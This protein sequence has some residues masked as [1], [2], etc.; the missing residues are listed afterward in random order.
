ML[1]WIAIVGW[2]G[3]GAAHAQEGAPASDAPSPSADDA[4]LPPSYAEGWWW[5]RVRGPS[6]ALTSLATAPGRPGWWAAVN[7]SGEV[8]VRP[9]EGEEAVGVL[10]GTG[11]NLQDTDPRR[12]I[13]NR[14]REL[15]DRLQDASQDAGYA[16]DLTDSSALDAIQRELQN[17]DDQLNELG[18][19]D[20]AVPPAVIGDL[21]ALPRVWF[22]ASA[23][24][25]GRGDGLW[26]SDDFGTS[27]RQV[28]DV[29]THAFAARSDG[30]WWVAGTDDG[31]RYSADGA[32]WFDRD[33]GTESVPVYDLAAV[34]AGFWAATATG[35]WVSA[36]GDAWVP[37]GAAQ[38]LLRVLPDPGWPGGGW[39]SDG[40]TV[41]R[42]DNAGLDLREPVGAPI[43]GVL[44]ILW[45]G[46]GRLFAASTDGAW[47]SIDGGT[48]WQ[49]RP[50]GLAD[51]DTHGLA[52]DGATLLL[53]SDEGLFRLA[54]SAAA[55]SRPVGEAGF[56]PLQQLVAV[57]DGREELR[58]TG[59]NRW[60][61]TTLPRVTVA[62]AYGPSSSLGWTLTSGTHR[63]AARDWGMNVQLSWSPKSQ[64]NLDD[65]LLP[66]DTWVV[67][68][69][70]PVSMAQAAS[71]TRTSSQY[72]IQVT[73]QVAELWFAR[74]EFTSIDLADASLTEQVQRA[75][76]IAEMD[77]RLDILCEGAVS[78]WR[79]DPS[80]VE[81]P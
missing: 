52:R 68:G 42:T 78:A 44:G 48:T 14:I 72:R 45:L 57:A 75:L 76:R 21:G 13:E 9:G 28:L 64:T 50:R 80:R 29:P 79:A 11:P 61:A 62:A 2:A 70:G 8:W 18:Q 27:W 56:V 66:V 69:D 39:I 32:Q 17:L 53:A 67:A 25:V 24:W 12:R 65:A 60:L 54:R 77:A 33:D 46:F 37:Q 30:A 16:G 38:A 6:G 23:L 55:Q 26:R 74:A 31:L 41:L 10:G 43:P 22:D 73:Q 47:E 3:W 1:G 34:D 81:S 63:T 36:D 4:F 49:P 59:G 20:R 40:R 51:P 19:D 58:Q 15:V 71:T 35:L 7:T 5:T